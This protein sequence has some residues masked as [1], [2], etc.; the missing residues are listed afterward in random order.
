MARGLRYT[1]E[2]VQAVVVPKLVE[3]IYPI[4]YPV[5]QQDCAIQVRHHCVVTALAIHLWRSFI[6]SDEAV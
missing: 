1:P 4:L 6:S 5:E 3:V 2:Q